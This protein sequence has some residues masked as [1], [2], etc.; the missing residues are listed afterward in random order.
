MIGTVDG[1]LYAL[2]GLTLVGAPIWS[3]LRSEER[4]AKL[5][6]GDGPTRRRMTLRSIAIQW[7]A[8][9]VLGSAWFASGRG[10]APLRLASLPE[11]PVAWG[12]V[13]ATLAVV[14]LLTVSW[15]RAMR[16]SAALAHLRSTVEP[17]VLGL[18][19]RTSAD[20]IR[21]VGLSVTAG[22]CEEFVYRGVALALLTEGLGLW[23]ALALTTVAFGASH[24][25]QGPRGMLRTGV[26]GLVFAGMVVVTGALS[27]AMAVHAWVD[28]VQGRLLAEAVKAPDEVDD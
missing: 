17:A 14:G 10:L 7:T 11:G 28:I 9:A 3:R 15:L 1:L 26:V 20:F 6:E 2:V 12:T 24:A 21:F 23:P 13:A 5:A 8:A 27:L 18:M 16:S 4:V 22:L 19:P 25:Y